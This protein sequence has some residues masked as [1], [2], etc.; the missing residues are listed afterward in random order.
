MLGAVRCGTNFPA[1][2]RG[3]S[4]AVEAGGWA[5]AGTWKPFVCL[6]DLK[7][8]QSTYIH[9][10]NLV[11]LVVHGDVPACLPTSLLTNSPAS[12]KKKNKKFR[13]DQFQSLRVPLPEPGQEPSHS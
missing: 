13:D 12:K 2:R 8:P 10:W 9:H 7:S 5:G 4:P 1:Q 6:F 3:C 11:H